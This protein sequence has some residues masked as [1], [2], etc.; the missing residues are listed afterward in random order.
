MIQ[1]IVIPEF[2]EYIRKF[3]PNRYKIWSEQEE[4]VLREYYGIVPTSVLA[5]YLDRSVK[6]VQNKAAALGINS[7]ENQK[8]RLVHDQQASDHQQSDHQSE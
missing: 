2:E 4:L 3:G 6:S 5:Q 7:R 1:K 8:R